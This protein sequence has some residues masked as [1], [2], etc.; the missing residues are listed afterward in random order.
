[1]AT[2]SAIGIDLGN[3]YSCVGVFQN[4]KLEIIVN[5]HGNRTTP[6][7]V[8]FTHAERLIG[9]AAKNQAAMNPAN[10]VSDAKRL[11]ANLMRLLSSRI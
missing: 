2:A 5:D 6:S 7:Y 11:G 1:M 4:G 8:A 9:Y 10:T 3:A